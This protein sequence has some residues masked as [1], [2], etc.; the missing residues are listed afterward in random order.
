MSYFS[1]FRMTTPTFIVRST[2]GISL[3]TIHNTLGPFKKISFGKLDVHHGRVTND[4]RMVVYPITGNPDP[5]LGM[6][7]LYWGMSAF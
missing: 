3:G 2:M 6:D 5:L 7:L 4:H 1:S